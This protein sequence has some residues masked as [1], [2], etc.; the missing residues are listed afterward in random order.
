MGGGLIYVGHKGW[1]FQQQRGNIAI[2]CGFEIFLPGVGSAHDQTHG[3]TVLLQVVGK[4][5]AF[6]IFYGLFLRV[7]PFA[8]P[9]RSVDELDTLVRIGLP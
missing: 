7:T 6:D 9:D 5:P 3:T 1:Q 2:S 4:L 8:F